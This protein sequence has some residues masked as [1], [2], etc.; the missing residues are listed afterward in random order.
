MTILELIRSTTGYLGGKGISDPRLDAEILLAG[1][2]DLK[3]L[4]LYLQFDRE[5]QPH[6]L[7]GFR[8]CVRRRARHEPMQYI[9][10]YA[11]FRELRLRVDPR[12]LIPRPETE[13][14]VGAVLG[15]AADRRGL[16]ALDV[17]TGS[18][19]IALSLATEGSCE[20]VVGVDPSAEALEVARA[21]QQEVA[22]TAPVVFLQGS[23]FDTVSGDRFD[24][25]V[26]N[27][28]YV[29]EGERASL[30][31]QVRDWEPEGA[32]FA[33]PEGLDV[34]A[35]LIS[36]APAFLRPGGLLALEIGAHQAEHVRGLLSATGAFSAPRI[37]RDLAGRDRIV[38]AERA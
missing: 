26:S 20:Q 10:G 1:V 32:L 35:P 34:I 3:R 17:G 22:P 8:E 11:H 29:A 14:L 28:P 4:D 30:E 7:A 38:L 36:E 19:A 31:S 33:G 12:V 6:E 9:A 37:A 23:L 5:V 16:R 2:L 13:V 24:V 21:N 15:W 18:G 25:V 27:P